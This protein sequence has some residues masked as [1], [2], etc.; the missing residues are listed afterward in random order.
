[1]QQGEETRAE[2]S[3]VC[4]YQSVLVGTPQGIV[5]LR[6][7]GP[8]V[9]L[10][11][12]SA[13]AYLRDLGV[14][15]TA[16]AIRARFLRGAGPRGPVI[17]EGEL[18]SARRVYRFSNYFFD[19]SHLL[20]MED[21]TDRKRYESIAANADMAN[22]TA[23]LLSS[24]RH[25]LGNPVNSLKMALSVLSENYDDFDEERRRRYV[26]R[27]LQQV[28]ALE[29]LLGHLR[30]FHALDALTP[31]LTQLDVFFNE[32]CAFLA[33]V[34]V[35]RKAELWAVPCRTPLPVMAHGRA[36]QQA[37]S[38]VTTNAFEAMEGMPDARLEMQVVPDSGYVAIEVRDNGPGIEPDIMREVFTPLFTTKDHGTGLGLAIVRNL[39]LGMQGDVEVESQEGEG[40]TVRLILRRADS[41]RLSLEDVAPRMLAV[42]EGDTA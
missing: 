20:F 34:A 35:A 42:G 17:E 19:G 23:I 32:N 4:P 13:R 7:S 28:K 2:P 37:L 36:L 10:I 38:N 18:A 39:M 3:F 33:E 14:I 24:L 8:E 1:M 22:N 9:L 11:N 5:L 6:I 30:S 40:T 21:V 25:E 27:S 41:M 26:E 29:D 12:A 31:E 15:E 16:E